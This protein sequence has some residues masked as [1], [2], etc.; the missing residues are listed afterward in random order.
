MDDDVVDWRT[1]VI[2]SLD[3]TTASLPDLDCSILRTC[4]H[5]FTLAVESDTRYIACVSLECE[6]GDWVGRLDI[7]ELDIVVTGR[8]EESLVGGD[9]ESVDLR[10]GVL[11]GSRAD[12]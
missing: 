3:R 1:M 2:A 9:A 6:N 8:R 7:V 12:S 11:D 10:F 4:D 5:P